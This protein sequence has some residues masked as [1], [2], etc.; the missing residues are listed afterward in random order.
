MPSLPTTNGAV[1]LPAIRT[2]YLDALVAGDATRARYLVD[3]AVN[4]GGRIPELYLEVLCPV[5]RDVG[6]L[7]A[8][9]EIN[10]AHEH[11]ATAVTQGVMSQL[12]SRW[13]KAPTSGR[14]AIVCATPGERHALG[15]QM[16]ADFLEAD[17]WEVLTLG[18]DTPAHDLGML[19]EL[20]R[21]DLVALSTAMRESLPGVEQT[22]ATLG[23]LQP[24]PFLVVGGRA[25]HD[26]DETR[27]AQMGADARILDPGA[28]VALVHDRFPALTDDD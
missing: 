20:E 25:W 28:L 10:V 26:L 8:A 17:G 3:D 11:Y 27:A 14:L 7:W 2:A 13:R 4:H 18:A 12:G 5:M 22:L 23:R 1:D 24:R 9:G 16:V 19:A 21:P 15:P 6:A